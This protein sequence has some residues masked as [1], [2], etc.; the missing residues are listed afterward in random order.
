MGHHVELRLLLSLT[1]AL[2]ALA[3]SAVQGR[4]S[5]GTPRSTMTGVYTAD[6]AA[7]GEQIYMNICVSCHPPATYTGETFRTSWG[8][9]PLSELFTAITEKM[10]KN[11]PGSLT[12]DEYAEVVAY[13]LQMNGI[14][15][16]KADLPGDVEALKTIR[17]E[18]PAKP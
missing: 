12:A 15:A 11:D 14:P 10:P 3:G 1:V 7:R 13:L 8:S 18:T 6:Q 17:V 4:Q 16:G 9:R 2:L 5:E